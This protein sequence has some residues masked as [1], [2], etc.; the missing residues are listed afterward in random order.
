[1][2]RDDGAVDHVKANLLEAV[3]G[4]IILKVSIIL[5]KLSLDN[6]KSDLDIDESENEGVRRLHR[7]TEAQRC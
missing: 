1:M 7:T 4:R 3:H 6:T 5:L 2:G